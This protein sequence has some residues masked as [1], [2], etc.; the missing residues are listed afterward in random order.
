MQKLSRSRPV[1]SLVVAP[2]LGVLLAG[3]GTLAGCGYTEQ[4]WQVQV[5]KLERERSRRDAAEDRMAR[6][7]ATLEEQKSR[8]T[9]LEQRLAEAGIDVE[10]LSTDL[11]GAT[12]TLEERERAIVEYRARAQKLEAIRA[13]F[14]T[15]RQKLSA[16]TE[17][18]L[19]VAVRKNRMVVVLP[20]DVLFDSGQDKI[21]KPGRDALKK[22]AEIIQAD[23]G[24][25]AREF[26]V[27]GHT[28]SKKLAGGNFGD[29]LGL[30]AMR[31]RQV[32]NFLTE[33]AGGGLTREKWSAAGYADTDP[34]SSNDTDEGRKANR[35]CEI[36]VVPSADE[37]LDLKALAGAPPAA[38]APAPAPSA[39]PPR[40]PAPQPSAAPKTPAPPAAPSAPP[41]AKK[42][43][44]TAP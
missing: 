31:A 3:A 2:L 12:T 14:E 26:Q 8:V 20:G 4:Q 38:P 22:V 9:G 11:A 43:Q 21:K 35:R 13:R 23:P 24:L 37:L 41:P 27:A 32:V 16:I 15:L 18:G 36:V 10:R 44:P 28:D 7:D 5:D 6:A 42:A 29:N 19:T 17:V 25:S 34:M 40:T 39:A 30:S 1:P 33:P